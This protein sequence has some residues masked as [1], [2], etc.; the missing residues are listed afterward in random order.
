MNYYGELL[1]SIFTTLS[2]EES[3]EILSLNQL[4]GT[5]QSNRIEDSF[6]SLCVNKFE[7]PS[8]RS[9]N[10]KCNTDPSSNE[11]FIRASIGKIANTRANCLFA[12]T[13]MLNRSS[14][15]PEFQ[16][17]FGSLEADQILATSFAFPSNSS[18][19]PSSLFLNQHIAN[20][21]LETFACLTNTH[22]ISSSRGGS[23]RKDFF[24][25]HG[26][27]IIEHDHKFK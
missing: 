21:N 7:L 18:D 16:E 3:F 19:G 13:P 23:W 2:N 6:S 27:V 26:A 9:L 5:N 10:L 12:Y 4:L 15:S 24:P 11:D 22:F 17:H 20:N 14:F 8:A 25:R 1:D